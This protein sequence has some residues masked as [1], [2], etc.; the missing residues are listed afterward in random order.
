MELSV[1][2]RLV[3]LSILPT[4]GD[5]VTLKILRELRENL[6]FSEE[7]IKRLNFVQE[8]NVV[9]WDNKDETTKD[10]SIGEKATDIIV[11]ALKKLNETK[12]LRDE[13]LPL[14]EKFVEVR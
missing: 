13:H 14:Y 11:A 5:Y 4:E 2:E 7:E 12:V 6:S 1:S 3:L 10:V 8:E 9:R